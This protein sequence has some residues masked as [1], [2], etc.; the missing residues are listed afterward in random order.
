[1]DKRVTESTQHGEYLVYL[2]AEDMSAVYL[3]FNQGVTDPIRDYGR[4]QGYA[5]LKD[6]AN[7]I[8]EQLPLAGFKKD[9]HIELTISRLGHDYQVSTVAYIRYDSDNIPEDEQLVADLKRLMENYQEYVHSQLQMTTNEEEH[10]IEFEELELVDTL[11]VT[12]RLSQIRAFIQNRG[13]SY[14]DRLIENFYLSMKTKP[15]VILAGISGTGKTKLVEL[16]AGNGRG[17]QGQWTVYSYFGETGLERS[18][19]FIRVQG[20]VRHF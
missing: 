11:S 3:T 9:E 8:R 13:F 4:R 7:R 16:F 20:F 6:K 17:Q 19:R 18:F 15:F 5:Y 12:E 14:P 1:M 2:F 10:E